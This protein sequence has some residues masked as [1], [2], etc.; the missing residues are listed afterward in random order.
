MVI[1][2]DTQHQ[3]SFYRVEGGAPQPIPHLESE[4]EII[5]WSSD[6]RSLYLARTQEM[7]I[8][9]YRFDP[10]TVSKELL[11][12][13]LPA[14]PAGIFSPNSILM[15]PDGMG[16]VYAVRRVRGVSGAGYEA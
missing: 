1:A 14:D 7:P 6:G 12:E 3:W 13:V 15:T 16:Y 2:S 10:S 8:R 5:G 4:D 9:V 11:E